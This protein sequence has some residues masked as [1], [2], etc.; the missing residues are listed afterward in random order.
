[1]RLRPDDESFKAA[2]QKSEIELTQEEARFNSTAQSNSQQRP[3]S[4]ANR[5][6]MFPAPNNPPA[7][8]MMSQQQS[9][10]PH[11]DD[12]TF[13]G[14]GRLDETPLETL[15][16]VVIIKQEPGEPDDCLA[17]HQDEERQGLSK[18]PRFGD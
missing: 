5:Y 15:R 14:E 7:E 6:T 17:N 8:Q 12:V 10:S 4:P 3:A 18:K 13:E 11:G 2:L 16:R 9:Q 1:M